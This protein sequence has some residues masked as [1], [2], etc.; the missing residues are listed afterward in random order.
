VERWARLGLDVE[1]AATNYNK[2][3]QKVEEG[4]YQIFMWGWIADYPDPENF[5]FLL[6]GPMA[7]AKSGGPNTAN[8]DDPAFNER[9]LAM[10][11]LE[12][13]PRRL[14]IIREIK[15]ILERE[16]PW[17]ELF[18]RESY[19]LYHAWMRNVKP[20]GLSLP[21]AKYVDIDPAVRKDLREKW[22]R[23]I[24]WPAYALAGLAVAIAFPGVLT[25]LRERQ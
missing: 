12:N 4:A 23:P 6:W 9:F 15:E 2:F 20:A 16:R 7:Q 10:K 14:A 21:A 19:A 8:F 11:N 24:R 5:L 18:H 1:I 22:N 17:I 13:G 25:F 3:R